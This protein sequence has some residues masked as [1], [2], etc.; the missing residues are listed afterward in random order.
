MQSG[1]Q[2]PRPRL[3]GLFNIMIGIFLLL[4]GY[5]VLLYAS[6]IYSSA[7]NSSCLGT[8]CPSQISSF[9]TAVLGPLYIFIGV[10]VVLV[11]YSMKLIVFGVLSVLSP[12][13][14]I[15]LQNSSST[16]AHAEE[17]NHGGIP[18]KPTATPPPPPPQ[19][20]ES[21]V[22]TKVERCSFCGTEL[23]SDASYC[24]KCFQKKR[25]DSLEAR[26]P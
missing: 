5:G 7:F 2:G 19:P 18:A 22:S 21:L 13:A 20:E 6:I 1:N 26:I 15:K 11:I 25:A 10:G 9:D 17:E 4:A 8:A 3:N 16:E 12:E 14:R 23:P 24:P